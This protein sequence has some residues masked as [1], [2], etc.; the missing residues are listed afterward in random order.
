M[1]YKFFITCVFCKYFFFI[2]GLA[3]DFLD[4]WLRQYNFQFYKVCYFFPLLCGFSCD[5]LEIKA[6]GLHTKA[7]AM[8]I[9]SSNFK[10]FHI[11]NLPLD[12]L[13]CLWFEL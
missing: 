5:V 8:S 11:L 1:Q 7:T 10:K 12:N 13:E 9:F 4:K 3:F 6:R 2:S